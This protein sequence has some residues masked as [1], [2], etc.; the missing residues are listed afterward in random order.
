MPASAQPRTR[1]PRE[2]SLRCAR[3]PSSV[4]RAEHLRA[5]RLDPAARPV[6]V[7]QD[8]HRLERRGWPDLPLHAPPGARRPGSGH[9]GRP[10]SRQAA[11][12]L[13][14]CPLGPRSPAPRLRPLGRP[15]L[16]HLDRRVPLRRVLHRP[17]RR[18]Q[19]PPQGTHRR[20]R[21]RRCQRCPADDQ[22]GLSALRPAR[23]GGPVRVDGG[24]AR[25]SDR[26][27]VIPHRCSRH[28]LRQGAGGGARTRGRAH[29]GPT[30]R[31]SPSPRRRP[32]PAAYPRGLWDHAARPGVHR[33]VHLCGAGRL[34][35]AGGVRRGAGDLPG[36]GSG[37]RWAH[38]QPRGPSAR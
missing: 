31:R 35:E 26:R 32:G 13:G 4:C 33:V 36:G 22:G 18:S 30:H 16:D 3:L 14:Q 37:H 24:L 1:S 19:R 21:P 2:T 34:R 6:D 17:A 7:G 29:L 23:G 20:R 38:L 10:G 5:R 27:R 11:A 25:G 12:R 8:D 9:L 15:T 28:R